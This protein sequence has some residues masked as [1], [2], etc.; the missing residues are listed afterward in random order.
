MI[1]IFFIIKFLDQEIIE[2]AEPNS[3][4][5]KKFKRDILRLGYSDV[6]TI[7]KLCVFIKSQSGSKLFSA[8]LGYP[9]FPADGARNSEVKGN[10]SGNFCF[11][12]LSD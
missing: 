5:F 6:I 11:E 8:L 9:Y 7:H 2:R 1:R 12:G 10:L 4:K 3:V